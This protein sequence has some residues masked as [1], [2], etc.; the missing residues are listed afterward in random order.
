[1]QRFVSEGGDNRRSEAAAAR[2]R[3]VLGR[4]DFGVKDCGGVLARSSEM[5]EGN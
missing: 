3:E 2:R 4:G 5:G 1:V